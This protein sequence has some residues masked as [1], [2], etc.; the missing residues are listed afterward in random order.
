ME[1]Y[2]LW[3]VLA[4]GLT[5][6]LILE[7]EAERMST[8]MW[9]AMV[10]FCFVSHVLFI[11]VWIFHFFQNPLR[12]MVM[13]LATCTPSADKGWYLRN[14]IWLARSWRDSSEASKPYLAFHSLHGFISVSGM[15][16]DKAWVPH[17]PQGHELPDVLLNNDEYRL[18]LS[19]VP[20]FLH[21]VVVPSLSA[22]LSVQRDV[23]ST[24][25]YL[26]DGI[27][28][29]FSSSC[30][31]FVIRAAFLLQQELLHAKQAR[32]VATD[33]ARPI[34]DRASE[35]KDPVLL[36]DEDEVSESSDDDELYTGVQEL[37]SKAIGRTL[38]KELRE[39]KEIL[40]E[41]KGMAALETLF[42]ELRSR[43][44]GVTALDLAAEHVTGESP[45]HGPHAVPAR[46]TQAPL[47]GPVKT[48]KLSS[49]M[50]DDLDRIYRKKVS[51]MFSQWTFQHGLP[52]AD[53]QQSLASLRQLPREKL[54]VWLDAFEKQWI[55]EMLNADKVIRRPAIL[56]EEEAQA[57]SSVIDGNARVG[58]AVTRRTRIQ[59]VQMKKMWELTLEKEET[60]LRVALRWTRLV[61]WASCGQLTVFKI[62]HLRCITLRERC[63]QRKEPLPEV[64]VSAPL[65]PIHHFEAQRSVLLLSDEARADFRAAK[66]DAEGRRASIRI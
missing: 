38:A 66:E 3:C 2:Q 49:E 1:R 32:L 63:S 36:R 50:D 42:R 41:W 21:Q 8:S 14:L 10:V 15:G 16:G 45:A 23:M 11:L 33:V 65:A 62:A 61:F 51:V 55:P 13:W 57:I 30:L 64:V 28:G 44:R 20:S 40:A 43:G 7:T 24:V 46:S 17:L 4:P 60:K 54:K 35:A 31:D 34:L 22:R 39:H 29:T 18:R 5:L 56:E 52:L 59:K 12:R 25:S 19:S 48:L 6:L 47:S 53:M 27:S 9:T 26:I 58:R 37:H